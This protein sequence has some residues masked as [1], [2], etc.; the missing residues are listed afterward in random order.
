MKYEELI[1]PEILAYADR[2]EAK[3]IKRYGDRDGGWGPAA[4]IGIVHALRFWEK[5][6]LQDFDRHARICIS[7]AMKNRLMMYPP[8]G[9]RRDFHLNRLDGNPDARP[10]PGIVNEPVALDDGP[11]DSRAI[12]WELEYQEL[13]ETLSK[14]LD[15]RQAEIF[16]LFHSRCDCATLRQVADKVDLPLRKVHV[17]HAKAV[18]R[19]KEYSVDHFV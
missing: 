8:K 18:R 12:G 13:V 2:L 11:I 6:D 9:Y 1:T 10:I 17:L 7:H 4:Q 19:L 14:K 16:R 15:S 3:Y 5:S